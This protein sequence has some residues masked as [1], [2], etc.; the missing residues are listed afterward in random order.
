MRT[1]FSHHTMPR[2]APNNSN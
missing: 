1:I 2:C